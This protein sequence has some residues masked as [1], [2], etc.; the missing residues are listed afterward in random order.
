[1]RKKKKILLSLV[2]V[3]IL[4]YAISMVP[5]IYRKHCLTKQI[6]QTID[7]IH[8]KAELGKTYEVFFDNTLNADFCIVSPPYADAETLSKDTG[9]NLDKC[10]KKIDNFDA[11]PGETWV[12][13]LV[14]DGRLTYVYFLPYG[15]QIKAKEKFGSRALSSKIGKNFG[16]K[17]LVVNDPEGN[18]VLQEI[19]T[20]KEKANW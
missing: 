5:S 17:I 20:N 1:M 7:A 11:H 16:F 13:L 3:A 6:Y 4:I 18:L 12:L 10:K 8:Q 14:K 2:G 9:V 19:L 15:I